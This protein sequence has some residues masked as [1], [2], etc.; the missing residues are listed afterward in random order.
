M[1]NSVRGYWT[2]TWIGLI[3]NVTALPLIAIIAFAGPPLQIANISLAISLAW[4]AAIVG[5][6]S[7]AGLLAERQWGVILTIVAISMSLA[8][9]MPYGIVR[10]ILVGDFH[11]ISTLSL[12]LAAFNLLGLIYWARPIHRRIRRL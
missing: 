4:P 9:S 8:A 7:S 12:L 2:L 10:L 1:S 3:G 6:V 11:S 5:I